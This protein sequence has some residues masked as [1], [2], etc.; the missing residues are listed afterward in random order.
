MKGGF[1]TTCS[2]SSSCQAV[3]IW[4]K[5]PLGDLFNSIDGALLCWGNGELVPFLW[6]LD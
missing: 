2:S 3:W 6:C 4:S 1:E 5:S